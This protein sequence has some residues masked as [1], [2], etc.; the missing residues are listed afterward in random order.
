MKMTMMMKMIMMM[1]MMKMTMMMMI[2]IVRQNYGM[3]RT[4]AR[5]I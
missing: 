3:L 4:S 2:S 5:S 1:K